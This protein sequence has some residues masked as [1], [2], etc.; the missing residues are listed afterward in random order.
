MVIWAVILCIALYPLYEW[1]A[2]KLGGRKS[3]ASTLLVLAGLALILGPVGAAVS[4]AIDVFGELSEK[5]S[6][7]TFKIPP[8]PEGLADIPLVGPKLVQTWSLFEKNL[9]AAM[10]TYGA[11]IIDFVMVIFGKAA[12]IG[13][14]LLGLALAVIIMGVLM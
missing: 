10:S 5:A 2:G 9:D 14:S 6:A 4:G 8:A 7:G 12:G 13:M 11:Q 3:L 1:L